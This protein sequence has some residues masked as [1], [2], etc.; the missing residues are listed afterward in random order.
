MGHQNVWR[1]MSRF[2]SFRRTNIILQHLRMSKHTEAAEDVLLE[3]KGCA[4]VITLNRPKLLNALNLNMTQQIYSQLKKWE[5]DPE[6]SL[7][8]IKGAG[9]KAFC[10]G[11]DIRAISDAMK[12]KQKLAEVFFKE[13]YILNNAIASLQKPYIALIDG[14]TMGGGV[15]ISVHGQFRVATEKSVFS[16]PETAI[17]LFPDV[18]GGYFLPRL[19]GKLGYFLA[20]T[21]FRLKGR[22]V[23]RVGIATHFV[24]SEKVSMLEEDLVALKSPSKENVA[25]VLETYH[26][27]SKIDQDKSFILEEHLDKINRCFS[28]NTV[29]QIIENLQQDGSPFALEQLKVINQMSPTSLKITLRHLIKGSSQTLKDVLTEEYRMSQ[30]CMR[31]HDF[32]EGVRAV[33]VDKDQSPKWKPANLKEVTDED[34]DNYFK[35]LGSND[36]KF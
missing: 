3:K 19:Q 2:N 11:G 14:I 27:Q 12:T 30:A 10:A 33:L 24:D 35:S 7:I 26:T 1:L 18:G 9:G 13:E 16:M 22:D 36:L 20:L 29:E 8:I 21:G 5:Q 32:H 6:T 28:A 34:L 31:G 15:G 23:Y 17:G 4:G 25:D